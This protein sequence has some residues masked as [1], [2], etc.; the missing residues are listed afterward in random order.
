[1]RKEKGDI[2]SCNSE[3]L[4]KGKEK[5][6]RIPVDLYCACLSITNPTKE[7]AIEDEF[8]DMKKTDVINMVI[9]A[10]TIIHGLD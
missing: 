2:K 7:C 1:M 8:V 9:E 3:E 5:D 6:V 4:K 10:H